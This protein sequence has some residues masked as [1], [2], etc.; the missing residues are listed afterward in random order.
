M[1]ASLHTSA[2]HG[3]MYR[4]EM[5][6]LCA[7]TADGGI[8]EQTYYVLRFDAD[9]VGICTYTLASEQK[10]Q[11]YL[12][13]LTCNDWLYYKWHKKG[14]RLLI[15]GLPPAYAAWAGLYIQAQALTAVQNKGVV[16]QRIKQPLP[17][18]AVTGKT[19]AALITDS[20]YIAFT[21]DKDSVELA[22]LKNI[23]PSGAPQLARDETR[24]RKRYR[25]IG[26][27]AHILIPGYGQ[28]LLANYETQQ[29]LLLYKGQYTYL[30]R[31]TLYQ[32]FFPCIPVEPRPV[33][34]PVKKK[35]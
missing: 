14:N 34:K 15:S 5:T 32:L 25:W 10:K 1:L 19:Y 4:M 6:G 8:N 12:G 28:C 22:H 30:K 21:F 29:L 11:E 31:E 26:L 27:G 9:S 24:E 33:K 17:A 2:Q 13:T 7:K 3:N 23:A 16:F 20:S 35:R 18:A